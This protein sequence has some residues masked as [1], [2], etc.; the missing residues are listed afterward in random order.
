MI[1]RWLIWLAGLPLILWGGNYLQEAQAAFEAG[2]FEESLSIYAEAEQA[3][4]RQ[5]Q[6]IRFNMA[7]CQETLDSIPQALLL[8]R[9]VA[10]SD[11]SV[12]AARAYNKIGYWMANTGQ[13]PEALEAFKQALLTD[14]GNDS[15]A[16]NYE[17]LL[18]LLAEQTAT[19]S[20]DSIPAEEPPTESD[21]P[22]TPE[23]S[24]D[25]PDQAS[26]EEDS[27]SP[28]ESSDDSAGA[29]P[30]AEMG[31]GAPPNPQQST[32]PQQRTQYS[33][34]PPNRDAAGSSSQD[35]VSISEAR[36]IL[37]GM[38]DQE[39]RFLQQLRRRTIGAPS[40]EGVPDW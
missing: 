22:Q 5:A 31:N 11:D 20:L 40:K 23:S 37:Q 32:N 12:L 34:T 7:I 2:N 13:A 38:Q 29:D 39:M 9:Q 14:P 36:R 17:L 21:S 33:F 10:T 16:Y 4:P 18:A 8:Y 25:T 30:E 19:N 6:R 24:D 27:S 35:T 15:A 1:S 28:D 26:D 3:Y